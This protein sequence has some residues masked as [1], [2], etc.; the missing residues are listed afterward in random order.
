MELPTR[1]I[2]LIVL[3][4]IFLAIVG[5][6]FLLQSGTEIS[7]ADAKKLFEL[8][9]QDYANR[10]CSWDITEEQSFTQYVTACK[11]LYGEEREAFSCLY[12]LCPG[13]KSFDIDYVRCAGICKGIEGQDQLGNPTEAACAIYNADTE[14]RRL[15]CKACG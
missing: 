10:G 6:F 1:A 2:I 5:S 15:G 9:C 12:S 3:L 4:V 8:R 11:I 13:C 7:K 14:C